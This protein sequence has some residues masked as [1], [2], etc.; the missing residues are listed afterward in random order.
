MIYD[1]RTYTLYPG[2]THEYL[3]IY[4]RE[5]L[6]VQREHLGHLV[7]YFT[8]EIGPLNKIIHIWAYE[9]FVE[10]DARREKMFSDA[11]FKDAAKKLYPL[12]QTQ[13]DVILK[14]TSFSPLK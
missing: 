2:K 8:S 13:E 6:P 9:S 14:G 12:I 10:R 4:E 5:A 7:G 3:E 11:R 1:F